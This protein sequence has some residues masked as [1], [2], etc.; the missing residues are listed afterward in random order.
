[1]MAEEI[2]DFDLA[3]M[4]QSDEA[5]AIFL[6]D[7]LETGDARHIAAALDVAAR[8]KGL[9]R[10]SEET[11]LPRE[12]LQRSLTE[13]ATPTLETTLAVLK[14]LGLGVSAVRLRAAS[15]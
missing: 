9:G 7:A 10:I 4:L 11:G 2:F 14:A 12:Q 13:S 5:I 6:S 1:M 8:A 15:S 3:D